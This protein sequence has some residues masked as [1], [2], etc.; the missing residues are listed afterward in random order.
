MPR[1]VSKAAANLP[2]LLHPNSRLGNSRDFEIK[3]LFITN[4]LSAIAQSLAREYGPQGVHVAH[5]IVDGLVMGPYPRMKLV[6]CVIN[7]AF[8]CIV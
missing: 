8:V 2:H 5:V 3:I 7:D 1:P 4:Q 6:M